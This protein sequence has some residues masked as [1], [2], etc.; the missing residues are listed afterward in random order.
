[1]SKLKQI[2]PYIFKILSVFLGIS[3]A[4]CI[5]EVALRAFNYDYV[6]I[7]IQQLKEQDKWR[8]DSQNK[9]NDDKN[10]RSL[11]RTDWRH[12]H[13][14][15]DEYVVYDNELIWRP[16]KNFVVFNEQGFKGPNVSAKKN[17]SEIRIVALGDSNTAGPFRMLGWPGFLEKVLTKNNYNVKVLNAGVWGYTSYQGVIRFKEMLKYE[18]DIVIICFGSNDAHMVP[19]SDKDY[20]KSK[21]FY[22]SV[23]HFK[24]CKL[25]FFII[26]S[27]TARKKGLDSFVHRVSQEDYRRNLKAMITLSR[28]NNI[29]VVLLTRPFIG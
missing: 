13:Q 1:M 20:L 16:K 15:E 25:L 19:V 17:S 11:G 21:E 27:I 18:P 24:L 3:F 10:I 14:L 12:F 5:S 26:D 8:E 6:P 4:L 29:Q 23:S 7:R 28:Q 2:N 22:K 9:F